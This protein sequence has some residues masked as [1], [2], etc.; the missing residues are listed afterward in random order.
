MIVGPST[1]MPIAWLHSTQTSTSKSTTEAEAV[2]L[3]TALFQAAYPILDLL[4]LVLG[5]KVT[6]KIKED[7][8]AT[9]EVIRKGYS[10]KLRHESRT[11]KPDLGVI[12][13]AIHDQKAIL[14]HVPTHRQVAE[15]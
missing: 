15:K 6:F 1:W 10:S 14:D 9:I 12:S 4:E 13:E 2:S 3:V 8:T 11:H 7:N 5:R